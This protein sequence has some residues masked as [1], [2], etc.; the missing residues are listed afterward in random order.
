MTSVEQNPE[1]KI[2]VQR[3]NIFR[4]DRRKTIPIRGPVTRQGFRTD[5]FPG[6]MI[7]RGLDQQQEGEGPA[8]K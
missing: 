4:K 5:I 6:D 7:V 3:G 2:N 8:A 1:G